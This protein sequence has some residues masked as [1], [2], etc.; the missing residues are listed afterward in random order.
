M[1]TSNLSSH[2]KYDVRAEVAIGMA[3]MCAQVDLS[4]VQ[5][6]M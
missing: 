5:S 2:R 3:T 4:L 6:P 1:W